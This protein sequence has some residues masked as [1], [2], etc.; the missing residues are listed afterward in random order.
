MPEPVRQMRP[1]HE[2][3]RPLKTVEP[4]IGYM[5]YFCA[6]ALSPLAVREVT[7]PHDN[8]SDPNIE[9]GTYGLFSTCQR[10]M[11]AS[12][13]NKGVRYLLF[14]CR[15]DGMRVVVGYYRLAWYADGVLHA[16]GADY[17]LAADK[18]HLVDPPVPLSELP[19]VVSSAATRPFR[20]WKLLTAEQASAILAILDAKP[21]KV[22]GYLAEVDRLERFQ[23]FHS[24]YRYVSWRQND[25]FTWDL[26]LQYLTPVRQ[27]IETGGPHNTSPTGFWQ[28]GACGQFIANK[29][30]LKMCP[31]CGAPASLQP[32]TRLP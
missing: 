20:L 8:K 25:P 31:H 1:S 29:A 3:W 26:A 4:P 21:N 6:D 2:P 28:C 15:R 23:Q 11:R 5:S 16:Q 13:V 32:V 7:R 30:L 18:V 24:G 14:V 10:S 27:G 17:A 22:E 19:E 12:V 9:T